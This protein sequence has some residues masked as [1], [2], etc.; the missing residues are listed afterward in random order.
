MITQLFCFY[1]YYI[2]GTITKSSYLRRR[3]RAMNRRTRTLAPIKAHWDPTFFNRV[4]KDPTPRWKQSGSVWYRFQQLRSMRG[5]GSATKRLSETAPAQKQLWILLSGAFSATQSGKYQPPTLSRHTR[6]ECPI[7]PLQEQRGWHWRRLGCGGHR[8]W[9]ST[10]RRRTAGGRAG[11][12]RRICAR[13]G[14]PRHQRHRG[15]GR[16]RRSKEEG[17]PRGVSM[18]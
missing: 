14:R 4:H 17:P 9:T 15:W 7:C 18:V 2:K 5:A 8:R 12:G 10:D 1:K 3:T 6:L 13:E 16:R 11:D